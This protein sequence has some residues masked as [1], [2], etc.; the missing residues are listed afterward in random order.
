MEQKII[1][2]YRIE[3]YLVF[4]I[5]IAMVIFAEFSR[6]QVYTKMSMCLLL[7]I[8]KLINTSQYLMSYCWR[9]LNL[10]YKHRR[11]EFYNHR[12]RIIAILCSFYCSLFLMFLLFGSGFTLTYCLAE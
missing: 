12:V 10:L 6:L 5:L 8:C 11:L 1:R 4:S 9:L 3:K 2:A 7:T